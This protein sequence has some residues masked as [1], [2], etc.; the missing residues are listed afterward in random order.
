[1]TYHTRA[2]KNFLEA[3]EYLL[4]QEEYKR[5][6]DLEPKDWSMAVNDFYDRAKAGEMDLDRKTATAIKA[7]HTEM[8][9]NG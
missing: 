2:E 6:E 8:I 5:L 3:V 7:F 4:P 9:I 1:M